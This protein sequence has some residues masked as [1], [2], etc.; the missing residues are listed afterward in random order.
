MIMKRRLLETCSLVMDFSQDDKSW[1]GAMT[2][3]VW[4][5]FVARGPVTDGFSGV[6][7]TSSAAASGVL[8]ITLDTTV[9][10]KHSD[11]SA[12]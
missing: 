10:L 1:R 4:L 12:N 11:Y 5:S 6:G 3:C 8:R 2:E 7:G 9:A